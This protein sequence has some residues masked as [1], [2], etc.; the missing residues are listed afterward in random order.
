MHLGVVSVD[1]AHDLLP[2]DL[3]ALLAY[4]P[5]DAIKP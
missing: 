2:F 3:S 1:Q 4:S 5:V